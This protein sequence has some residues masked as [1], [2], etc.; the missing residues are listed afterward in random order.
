MSRRRHR[1]HLG[2]VLTA[3]SL[4][5]SAAWA[6]AWAR[7]YARCDSLAYVG[8]P[9]HGR[10][11][12]VEVA[13]IPGLFA[14]DLDAVELDMAALTEMPWELAT[15]GWQATTRRYHRGE[16]RILAPARR[17][18][19][20]LDF[21]AHHTPRIDGLAEHGRPSGGSGG[22]SQSR[23]GRWCWGSRPRSCGGSGNGTWRLRPGR[24]QRWGRRR[25]PF[26]RRRSKQG[27]GVGGHGG[28]HAPFPNPS[29]S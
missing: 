11:W 28:N 23:T 26:P 13:P 10:Y 2:T 27:C 7:S 3:A 19:R 16:A 14:C 4:V 12:R 9:A 20:L 21:A 8:R 24:S 6:A 1:R 15:P 17:A 25:R 5:L 22:R 29:Y 18:Y